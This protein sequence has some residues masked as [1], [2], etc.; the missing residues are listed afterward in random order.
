MHANHWNNC[1]NTLVK[2]CPRKCYITS[3]WYTLEHFLECW[4]QAMPCYK[5]CH[6]N[7]F[8]TEKKNIA[9]KCLQWNGTKELERQI[10]YIT[11]WSTKMEDDFSQL[12]IQCYQ[13]TMIQAFC[14][15]FTWCN[16]KLYDNDI[17]WLC[18]TGITLRTDVH[19]LNW[20]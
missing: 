6:A 12:D 13:D 8:A 16:I 10:L 20:V 19:Y 4:K 1:F 18:N 17:L 5:I 3:L 14:V 9:V 15:C 11:W 2:A 7:W